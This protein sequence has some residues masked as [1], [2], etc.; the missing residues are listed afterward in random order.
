[1]PPTP[2]TS[3]YQIQFLA[4]LQRL[5]AE[6]L[7]VATYK[8]AL[9]ISLADLAVEKGDDFG[10]PM[11]IGTED[12]AEK[13]VRYYWRQAVPYV[14]PGHAAVLQQNAGLQA[15]VVR[16]LEAARGHYG[17][18]LPKILKDQ[19]AKRS[20]IREID[21][22][23]RVMPLWKL[24]TVGDDVLEF[25]YANTGTGKS[26]ELKPGVAFCLRKFYAL[27]TDL[28]RGAWL[29]YVRQK[30]LGILGET[31]DLSEFLFG[32]ERIALAAARP[33]LMDIQRGQCFYCGSGLSKGGVEVDHFI[34][35]SRYGTDL[36]HNFVLADRACNNQ[37]RDRIAAVEHL[38]A[39]TE[40]NTRH[41]DQ[42]QVALERQGIVSQREASNRV[43]FWAYVLVAA[44]EGA[45]LAG[46]WGPGRQCSMAVS[47]A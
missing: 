47:G 4:N 9:L 18:S 43:A 8:F 31:T 6:G 37:K 26:I 21:P 22:V 27:V 24:Q 46:Q 7:F 38:A 35:W 2:P 19:S 20:L 39:W 29:R 42:I 40:R 36:G 17:D 13:F 23:V 5:L 41:G 15:K 32:S 33:V 12:I 30:N 10:G 11:Q 34:P 45:T 1:M 44:G 28:V 14:T 3:D 16:V 25:L